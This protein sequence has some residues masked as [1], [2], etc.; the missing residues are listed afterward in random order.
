MS[1]N[2]RIGIE[3]HIRRHTIPRTPNHIDMVLQTVVGGMMRS[4]L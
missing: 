1:A 3:I 4:D 2:K